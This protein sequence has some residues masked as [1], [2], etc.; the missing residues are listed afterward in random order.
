MTHHDCYQ[1]NPQIMIFDTSGSIGTPLH[2]Y[3]GH[4]TNV[5]TV[6]FQSENRWFLSASEDGSVRIWDL[7]SSRCQR[8]ISNT[9]EEGGSGGRVA[10]TQAALHPNQ[11]EVTTADVEGRIRTWNV[12]MRHCSQEVYECTSEASAMRS[13]SVSESGRMIAAVN[14]KVDQW[15]ELMCLGAIASLD[16]Q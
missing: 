4:R 7:R 9:I 1:G 6:A 5:T 11:V 13:V 15:D 16:P 8:E 14:D 10:I 12:G 3:E 2:I